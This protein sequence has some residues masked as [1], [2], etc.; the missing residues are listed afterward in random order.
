MNNFFEQLS[1]HVKNSGNCVNLGRSLYSAHP[2]LHNWVMQNTMFLNHKNPKFTQRIWCILNSITEPMVDKF[3]NPAKFGNLFQGYSLKEYTY[4]KS[5]RNV[6]RLVEKSTSLSIKAVT[7]KKTKIEQFVE[8]NMKR[9]SDLYI[10]G[11]MG[12]NC[13]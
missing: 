9:N 8:R 10:N 12:T 6:E 3:G 7:P 1:N 5:I 4:N 11:T 13:K 2:I